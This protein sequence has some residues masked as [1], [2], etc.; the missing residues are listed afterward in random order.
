LGSA[1]N[2]SIDSDPKRWRVASS[3]S[4]VCASMC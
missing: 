4:M 2:S 3:L 1:A